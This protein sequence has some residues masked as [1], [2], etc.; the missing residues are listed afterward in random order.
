MVLQVKY[1]G[2]AEDFAWIVPVPA[3]PRVS[4]IKAEK[5][6]FAEI[7]LYTQLR[8]R[9][10]SRHKAP[11][12]AGQKVQVLERKV[13]GVY[14][15]AVLAA[16]EA[17]ALS[18][19]LNKHGYAFPK[20]RADVLAHY[21]KKKW[22]Y[23]AM[24]ID[25]K[26]LGTDK[27]KALK[28]GELQPIRFT[29]QA[30][31]LVYPLR[32]SCVNAGPTDVLLYLVA[33]A[34][35]VLKAGPGGRGFDVVNNMP[36]YP[37]HRYLDSQYGTFR[38]AVGAE[39]PLTWEALGLRR[40]GAWHLCKYHGEY[41]P[42]DM[43]DD[44]TFAAFDPLAH[45]R[46]IVPLHPAYAAGHLTF[47]AQ[48]NAKTYVPLLRKALDKMLASD[49]A[50]VRCAVGRNPLA[51]PEMLD[52]LAGDKDAAVQSYVA[53]NPRTPAP[54]LR[55]LAKSDSP[56]VREALAGNGNTPP[57]VLVKLLDDADEHVVWQ[58]VRHL[59]LPPKALPRKMKTAS[60][61]LR[62]RVANYHKTPPAILAGLAKDEDERVRGGAAW[63]ANTPADALAVLAKDASL[64]VRSRVAR[65][66]AAPAALLAAL[67]EDARVEVRECVANNPRTPA[68]ALRRLARSD[69]TKIRRRVAANAGTPDDVL[70]KL[71]QDDEGG[72]RQNAK[73]S[74][75]KRHLAT[76]GASG[77]E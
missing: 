74:L 15:V 60:V 1:K 35:M 3:R 14:D 16:A 64:Y 73:Q 65:N 33:A 44:L 5:S 38:R 67:A 36:Q 53:G 54:A 34:P 69:S 61:I 13:V 24:R 9:W 28:T 20:D 43:S 10:G 4:A 40:D 59:K 27:V 62:R 32:I 29:F 47:L 56:R 42:K 25:R 52:R 72:V 45:W 6:P 76:R 58:A 22:V 57:A 12:G 2:P 23:V 51:P 41:E 17:K 71:A 26:A 21:T 19:W 11:A 18:G 39:L 30:K 68:A 66:R 50:S 77:G 7:S 63:N 75:A 55:R 48:H 49:K 31:E 46:R 70:R 37:Q 8:A